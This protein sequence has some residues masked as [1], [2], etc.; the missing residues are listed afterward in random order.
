MLT[1]RQHKTRLH[2]DTDQRYGA[3]LTIGAIR[4]AVRPLSTE[5][6]AVMHSI[7]NAVDGNPKSMDVLDW[8]DI[9]S[10]CYGLVEVDEPMKAHKLVK[11]DNSV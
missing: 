3:E 9:T 6:L 5:Q 8:K 11:A 1:Y 7:S 4:E 2:E 10:A